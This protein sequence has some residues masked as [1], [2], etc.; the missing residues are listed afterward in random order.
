MWSNNYGAAG[1]ASPTFII[2]ID[3]TIAILNVK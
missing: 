2:N 1:A 3:I